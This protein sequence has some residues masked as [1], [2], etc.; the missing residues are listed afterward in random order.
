MLGGRLRDRC[1]P[2]YGGP[3]LVPDSC[4]APNC[5][6]V[7]WKDATESPGLASRSS[8]WS[9][10]VDDEQKHDNG[11]F[12]S[13]LAAE[14]NPIELIGADGKTTTFDSSKIA[15]SKEYIVANKANGK[16]LTGQDAP[17]RLVGPGADD[18]S[19]LG[20]ITRIQLQLPPK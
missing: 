14:G 2:G 9:G 4:S 13:A 16:E 18:S 11:A 6:G 17:L 15:L 19:S 10:R 8:T 20:G 5:H 3:W 1:A 12:N 7:T